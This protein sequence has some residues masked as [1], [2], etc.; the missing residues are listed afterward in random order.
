MEDSTPAVQLF[1][2]LSNLL[3]NRGSQLVKYAS[4]C[5]K[6]LEAI[7]TELLSPQLHKVDLHEEELPV[8]KTL[9]LAWDPD[10]T[11]FASK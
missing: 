8:H 5:R 9:G 7:S 1:G 10:S 11:S 4:N 6:V 2:E 3:A